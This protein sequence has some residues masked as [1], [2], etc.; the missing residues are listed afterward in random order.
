MSGSNTNVENDAL[1]ALDGMVRDISS[2]FEQG[3]MNAFG[4]AVRYALFM[5]QVADKLKYS[6]RWMQLDRR[7]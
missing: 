3:Q 4:T 2:R 6:M 1:Y 5:H 7:R